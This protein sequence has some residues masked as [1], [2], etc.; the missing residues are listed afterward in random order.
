M[1]VKI[2][3]CI[4]CT[5]VKEACYP[6]TLVETS[7]VPNLWVGEFEVCLIILIED[8]VRNSLFKFIS[9]KNIQKPLKDQ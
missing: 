8:A 1:R 5:V 2:A 9:L 4:V 7:S 3:M 6:P